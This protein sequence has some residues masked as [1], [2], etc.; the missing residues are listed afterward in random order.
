MLQI[1]AVYGELTQNLAQQVDDLHVIDIAPVQLEKLEGKLNRTQT[2]AQLARMNAEALEY[3]DN[4]FDTSLMFLLLHEMPP[5]ARRNSLR[6]AL[7]VLRPGGRFVLAEY[8]EIRQNHFIHRFP[9]LRW[10]LTF[11]EPFLDGF[12]KE[13]LVEV[14]YRCGEEVG[15]EVVLIE[16]KDIFGGF[17]RVLAFEVR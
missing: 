9:P 5:E 3:E 11:S 16:Q 12:W 6:E 4:S 8:G 15:K 13:D 17:Y 10:T 14:V 1:A 2:Q 7:R